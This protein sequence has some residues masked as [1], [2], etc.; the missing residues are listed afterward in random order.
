MEHTVECYG[1]GYSAEQIAQE[2]PGV[3]L[4]AIYAT[5]AYYLHVQAAVDAHVARSDAAAEARRQEWINNMPELSRRVRAIIDQ[6]Q[7]EPRIS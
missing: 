2:F 6:G 5:I 4:K 3:E 1:E 7:Q